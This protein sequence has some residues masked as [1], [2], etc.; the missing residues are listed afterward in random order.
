MGA[1]GVELVA[2]T[3]GLGLKRVGVD[4]AYGGSRR[5][6]FVGWGDLLG[7]ASWTESNDASVELGRGLCRP[8]LGQFQSR[9]ARFQSRAGHVEA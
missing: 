7:T 2:Q 3:L 8:G 1:N 6:R 9:C 4:A 5:K